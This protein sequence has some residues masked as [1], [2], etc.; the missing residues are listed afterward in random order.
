V[1]KAR[2]G[3]GRG[4]GYSEGE[5]EGEDRGEGRGEVKFSGRDDHSRQCVVEDSGHR[6]T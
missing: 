6:V 2:E 1:D 4:Q 5:S 3:R